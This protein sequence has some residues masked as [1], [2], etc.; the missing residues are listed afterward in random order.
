MHRTPAFITATAIIIA[1]AAAG[2]GSSPPPVTANGTLA[3]ALAPNPPRRA[4]WG[5]VR[6][7]GSGQCGTVTRCVTSMTA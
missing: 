6:E 2:C 7:K 3:G 1:L 5:D 4:R